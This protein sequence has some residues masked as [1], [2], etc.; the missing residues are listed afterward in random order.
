M[1]YMGSKNRIAKELLP[2]IT[3]YLTEDRWYVEP[4]CGGC[5]MIDKVKHNKRIAND[6]NRYL[7][8]LLKALQNGI[9][10][11]TCV[12]KEEYDSVRLNK[13]NYPDWYVGFI[14][15]VCSYRGKFFNGWI[16]RDITQK[17]GNIRNRFVEQNN[18]FL[19]Q[20]DNIMNILFYNQEYL[21]LQI[22]DNSIIY[23]DPPYQNT[24][25]YKTGIEFNHTEFWEWCRNMTAKGNDVLISEYNAP[26][27]FVCIWG[28]SMNVN[29]NIGNREKSKIAI[30]KLFVHESIANKYNTI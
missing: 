12:S 17:T 3:R 2:I 20:K 5:N 27:D 10:F 1:V 30:E 23:C 21:N 9:E 25:I 28:K 15:F 6:C 18:N 14:G 11:P 19:K 8:A 16:D 24:T 13:V 22:P 4:F 26:D 29:L 7:I